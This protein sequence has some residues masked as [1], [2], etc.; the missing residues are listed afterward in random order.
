MAD[1]VTTTNWML[2]R[3]NRCVIGSRVD[4]SIMEVAFIG[5]RIA[6]GCASRSQFPLPFQHLLSL[7]ARLSGRYAR[8]QFIEAKKAELLAQREAEVKMQEKM[9]GRGGPSGVSS[10]DPRGQMKCERE[11]DG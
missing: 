2:W 6:R 9:M 7:R 5:S 4:E 3:T 8:L 1:D 10:S 11:A